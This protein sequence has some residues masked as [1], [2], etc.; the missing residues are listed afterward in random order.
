MA[1]A[2]LGLICALP[3]ARAQSVD[4]QYVRIYNLIQEGD[5]LNNSGR[6]VPALKKYLEAQVALQKFKKV[7][8]D[9]NISV[10][11]FRLNYLASKI[12]E[13]SAKAPPAPPPAAPTNQPPASAGQAAQAGELQAQLEILQ[14]QVRQLQAERMVMEARLKEAFASQPASVDPRE[15]AK[16]QKK[17]QALQKQNDLLTVSLNFFL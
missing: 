5:S 16:A 3:H 17:I 8:P 4:D 6:P 10:V 11:D 9:W 12:A 2:A 14:G 15:F 1:I 7:Y 13:A